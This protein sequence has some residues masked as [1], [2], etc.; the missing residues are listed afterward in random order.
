[1]VQVRAKDEYN[2]VSFWEMRTPFAPN[3]HLHLPGAVAAAMDLAEHLYDSFLHGRTA[4]VILRV[5]GTWSAIYRLHRVVLIQAGFFRSLFT[6]G[7]EEA[8]SERKEVEVIFDD[9]N[10]TRAAFE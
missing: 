10:I 4:D 3:H 9:I 1:M 6:S 7:F 5:V 2:T 8:V